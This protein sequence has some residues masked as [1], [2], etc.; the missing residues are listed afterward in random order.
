MSRSEVVVQ[1]GCARRLGGEATDGTASA[2]R[3][4]TNVHEPWCDVSQPSAMSSAYALA[5]VF[6]ATLRSAAS[7]RLD[8]NWI[9]GANRPERIAS[10]MASIT[11]SRTLPPGRSK[12]RSNPATELC[13]PVFASMSVLMLVTNG[14]PPATRGVL[15][16]PTP[17]EQMRKWRPDPRR[18]HVGDPIHGVISPRK[19]CYDYAAAS[20]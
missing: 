14:A 10:R 17:C 9:P 2:A 4:A 18:S 13:D 6:L 1:L 3:W 19:R 15:R 8:G 7:A 16:A 20:P 11:P 5:T 12:W